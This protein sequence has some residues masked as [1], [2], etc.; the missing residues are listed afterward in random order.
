MLTVGIVILALAAMALVIVGGGAVY[1]HLAVVPQWRAA[2]P[3]SLTMFQGT[4]AL[5]PGRFWPFAHVAAVTL[6]LGALILDW[7]TPARTFIEMALGGYGVLL[8]VTALYFLPE[9]GTITRTPYQPVADAAL[10]ARAVRWE[11]FSLMRLAVLL[12]LAFVLMIGLTL[13]RG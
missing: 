12:G 11:L 9:L 3:A 7:R 10:T 1:E 5:N 6:L 4:Y 13:V 8:I 2:P